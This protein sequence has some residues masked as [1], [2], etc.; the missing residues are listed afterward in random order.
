MSKWSDAAKAARKNSGDGS[1][2]IKLDDGD[3]V[4]FALDSEAEIGEESASWKD[5]AKVPDGTPGSE[6]NSKIVLSVY[7]LE[8]R[9]FRVLR[10]GPGTF[11]KLT[12]KLDKF[13]DDRGYCL[14]RIGV[15]M[16]TRYEIDRLDK[17]TPEQSAHMRA[18]EPIDV[19]GERGVVPLLPEQR[20]E[21]AP[22]RVAAPKP[23]GKARPAAMPD[24]D[25]P[26][27]QPR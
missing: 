27:S 3:S 22:E 6:R 9:V 11:A 25:V 20:P 16:K 26:F 13:G 17:L 10:L 8:A 15:G 12:E 4:S 19:L 7:D 1:K 23:A 14:T 2:Y 5:G 18:C 24:E 21:P